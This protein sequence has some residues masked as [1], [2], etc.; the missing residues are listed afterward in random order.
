MYN[1]VSKCKIVKCVGGCG[2]MGV[3]GW[4]WVDGWGVG[5]RGYIYEGLSCIASSSLQVG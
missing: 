1:V 2:W 5:G 4:V 3:G